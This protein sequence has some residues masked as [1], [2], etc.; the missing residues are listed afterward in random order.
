[1]R[2]AHVTAMILSGVTLFA[3]CGDDHAQQQAHDTSCDA[4]PSSWMSSCMGVVAGTGCLASALNEYYELIQAPLSNV[5][6]VAFDHFGECVCEHLK[7]ASFSDAVTDCAKDVPVAT[8]HTTTLNDLF[9]LIPGFSCVN[10]LVTNTGLFSPWLNNEHICWPTEDWSLPTGPGQPNQDAL[11]GSD[12]QTGS[13]H[14]FYCGGVTKEVCDA[15][16]VIHDGGGCYEDDDC[17]SQTCQMSGGGCPPGTCVANSAHPGSACISGT[18]C[19]GTCVNL[20]NNWQNCGS[21]GNVC[22]F[23]HGHADGQTCID[24]SCQC[25]PGF[26]V[27]GTS[28]MP[29]SGYTTNDNCGACHNYCTSGTT[30]QQTESD[31]WECV[32]PGGTMDCGDGWGCVDLSTDQRHCG[33]CATACDSSAIC[34]GGQCACSGGLTMCG[35]QCKNLQ[36]DWSNC[37]ACDHGCGLNMA[38]NAGSCACNAGY[39]Q[40]GNDCYDLQ[41]SWLNCGSCGHECQLNE[42]CM[43]GSCVATASPSPSASPS[44]TPS[45]S[46]GPSPS[47]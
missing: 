47:P 3:G 5:I 12:C 19:Y 35:T 15:L 36:T 44:P 9:N 34:S 39:T 22:D 29:T 7:D 14:T 20:Q 32:C 8:S 17:I 30:C 41:T 46:M 42:Q 26:E 33:S 27:C 1:M 10:Y 21:C 37:G 4:S 18:D 45:P 24:G 6:D 38:C 43:G 11:A 40:C 23:Q 2:A 25:P 13:A 16:Y 28:C 31:Y